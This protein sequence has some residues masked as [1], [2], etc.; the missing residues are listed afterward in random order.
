MTRLL[1]ALVP[2]ALLLAGL[3]ALFSVIQAL[4]AAAHA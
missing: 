2:I 3:S 1:V 4:A